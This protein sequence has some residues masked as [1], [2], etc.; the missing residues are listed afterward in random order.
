MEAE[1]DHGHRFVALMEHC[2]KENIKLNLTKLQFKLLE[3]KFMD[4]I[5]KH[6]MKA[7]PDKIAVITTM[8][9][10]RNR[11]DLQQFLGMASYLSPYC[12]NLSTT[13]RPLTALT[14]KDIPFSWSK[15]QADAFS[16]AK[17]LLATAPTLHPEK[18]VVLH[19]DASEEG[20][21]GALLQ[22]NAVG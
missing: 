13:I 19:V 1:Q 3:V 15:A 20:L 8:L 7:D 5:T 16:S 12:P 2:L 4:N 18:P 14:Q 9:T 11:A 22:P 10:P 21:G 6:G 17:K